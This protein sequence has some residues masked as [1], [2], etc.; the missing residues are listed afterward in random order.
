MAYVVGMIDLGRGVPLAL[1]D[2]PP[3][4]KECRDCHRSAL[5]A[6]R[7]LQEIGP[8]AVREIAQKE[9]LARELRV[10]AALAERVCVCDGNDNDNEDDNPAAVFRSLDRDGNGSLGIEEQCVAV[11]GIDPSLDPLDLRFV[12]AYLH[13]SDADL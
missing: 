9:E 11:R 3:A 6:R 5:S 7:Q 13:T 8:E 1:G 2:L 4:V 12:L 10:L